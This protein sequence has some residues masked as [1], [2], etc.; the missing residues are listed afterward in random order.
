M[1]LTFTRFEPA[2]WFSAIGALKKRTMIQRRGL[3]DLKNGRFITLTLDRSRFASPEIGYERGNDRLRRMA[4]ACR[5]QWGF[6]EYGAKME[7][8][9]E[10]PDWVHWHLVVPIYHPID[11]NFLRSAWGLGRIDVRRIRQSDLDYIWKYTAKDVDALPQ[12]AADRERLRV[13]STSKNFYTSPAA[14]RKKST[15]VPPAE[16]IKRRMTTLG[17]R[18]M[19]SARSGLFHVQSEE[20]GDFR[21]KVSDIQ[22][23]EILA[24]VGAHKL[25]GQH[26]C[27]LSERKITAESRKDVT[28]LLIQMQQIQKLPQCLARI[29]WISRE[30]SFNQRKSLPARAPKVT[31]T[32]LPRLLSSAV[33]NPS[34]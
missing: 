1:I 28:W 24:I 11:L 16:T 5:K 15:A 33:G 3:P 25:L 6:F 29:L 2:S 19:K 30:W 18:L 26:D 10:N 21:W 14:P 4:C 32:I 22:F 7:F 13:W 34:S 8:H 31:T 23:A 20:H 27:Q 17:E 12:W 9:P